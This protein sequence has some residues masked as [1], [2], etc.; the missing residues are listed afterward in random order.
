MH[1]RKQG[2]FRRTD[3]QE[4][5]VLIVWLLCAGSGLAA[6]PRGHMRPH[7]FSMAAVTRSHT[8]TA[9]KQ[10]KCIIWKS[11]VQMGL[12][13]RQARGQR[14]CLPSGEPRA[15]SVFSP[16]PASGHH[17]RSWLVAPSN[18]GNGR[19]RLFTLTCSNPD[20]LA[21]FLHN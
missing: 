10:V 5:T 14:V 17:L 16:F 8:L 2:G 19:P 15:E 7:E 6:T 21:S 13:G 1:E 12:T 20:C 4:V 9:L 3:V 11:Q 18:L